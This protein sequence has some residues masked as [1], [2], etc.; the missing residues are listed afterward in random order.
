MKTQENGSVLTDIYFLKK[1]MNYS[2]VKSEA[3]TR[4]V[5]SLNFKEILLVG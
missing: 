4:I 5:Y 3:T 1:E 2:R